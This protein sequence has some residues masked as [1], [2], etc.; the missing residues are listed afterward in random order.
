MKEYTFSL[1]LIG[2]GNTPEEAFEDV[3]AAVVENP[4]TMEQAC[5]SY[6][7]K[8]KQCCEGMEVIHG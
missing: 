6:V 5:A 2:C 7:E 8:P 4:P 1:L 3:L